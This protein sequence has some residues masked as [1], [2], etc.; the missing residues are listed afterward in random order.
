MMSGQAST[1]QTSNDCGI[2]ADF[3]QTGTA[4]DGQ[5]VGQGCVYPASVKTFASQL[6]AAELTRKGYERYEQ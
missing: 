6:I 4:P 2:F 1:P 3:H 5:A